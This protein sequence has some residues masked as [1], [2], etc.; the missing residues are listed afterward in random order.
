MLA[1]LRQFII[2]DLPISPSKAV[3]NQ[4]NIN[5]PTSFKIEFLTF[6]R[7]GSRG[8]HQRAISAYHH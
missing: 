2:E 7:R 6:N 4:L 8:R 5:N 1:L 3:N